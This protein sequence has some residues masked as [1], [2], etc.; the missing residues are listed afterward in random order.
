MIHEDRMAYGVSKDQSISENI[1]SDRYYKKE[2][3]RGI[4]LRMKYIVEQ[5]KELIRNFSIKCDGPEARIST[6]SGGNIQK[7]VAAREFSS[8]PKLLI[9]SHPT[10]VLT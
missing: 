5:A 10:R 4:M 1:V 3:R 6:L 8:F 7:V 9:A 2:Y